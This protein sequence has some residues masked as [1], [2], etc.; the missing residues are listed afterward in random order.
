MTNERGRLL[1]THRWNKVARSRRSTDN[2][3]N[4]G[5]SGCEVTARHEGHAKTENGMKKELHVPKEK[6]KEEH[7]AAQTN[8]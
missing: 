8:E 1:T 7:E 6:L 2:E 4:F 5:D 3:R